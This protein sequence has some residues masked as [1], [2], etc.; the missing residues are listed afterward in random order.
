M[1]NWKV[2]KNVSA[3]DLERMLNGADQNG[4]T[5]F[6][7]I[8]VS[9]TD[10]LCVFKE[11]WKGKSEGG[12]GRQEQFGGARQPGLR[13]EKQ[14][15]MLKA[16]LREAGAPYPDDEREATGHPFVAEFGLISKLS[17][18]RMDAALKWISD[19]AA[20]RVTSSVP[21]DSGFDWGAEG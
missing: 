6:Q 13:S 2:R 16:R 4:M 11:K 14:A 7:L 1:T 9:N 15:G 17:W 8:P 10:Y 21:D 18:K 5:L 12:S 19:F 3:D 20:N